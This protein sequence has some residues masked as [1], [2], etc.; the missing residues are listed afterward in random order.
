[1][2]HISGNYKLA[3]NRFVGTYYRKISGNYLGK[4]IIRFKIKIDVFAMNDRIV[5]NKG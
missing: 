3:N 2:V 5:P 4:L 1:M